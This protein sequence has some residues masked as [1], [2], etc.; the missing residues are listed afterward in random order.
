MEQNQNTAEFARRSKRVM[1]AIQLKE[2]DRVPLSPPWGMSL[3]WN[4]AYP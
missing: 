4:T 1:D 2:P 3:P